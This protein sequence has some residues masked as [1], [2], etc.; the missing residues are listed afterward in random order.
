MCVLVK[1]ATLRPWNVEEIFHV[2]TIRQSFQSASLR[3]SDMSLAEG[4]FNLAIMGAG[5]S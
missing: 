5:S 3:N 4:T 2:K 1:M